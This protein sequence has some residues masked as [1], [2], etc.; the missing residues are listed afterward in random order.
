MGWDII[1]NGTV[2]V[3]LWRGCKSENSVYMKGKDV[4]WD[5]IGNGT[6]GVV[7]WRGSKSGHGV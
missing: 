5:A 1:G 4:G 6:V 3:V 7:L 2:G